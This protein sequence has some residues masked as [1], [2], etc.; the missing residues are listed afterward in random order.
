MEWGTEAARTRYVQD[1]VRA[2][3]I[4]C[5][6]FSEPN[7]GSDLASIETRIEDRGDHLK[8]MVPRPG[9]PTA[10][11]PTRAIVYASA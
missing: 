1:L 3:K 6:C 9:F 2:K 10:P 11:M 7:A 8:S 5:T 4:G